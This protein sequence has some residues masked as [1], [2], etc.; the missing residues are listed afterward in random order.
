MS[1]IQLQ[2]PTTQNPGHSVFFSIAFRPFFAAGSLVG[3]TLMMVW[4]LIYRGQIQLPLAN[5]FSWH[6]HEMI[7]AYGMAIVAGFLLTAV[8][9]WT[10]QDTA[11]GPLLIA[12]LIVWLLPRP[13]ALI[14]PP[15]LYLSLLDLAFIPCLAICLAA[16]I[17]KS[18]NWRNLLFIPILIAF[19]L[20]NLFY[21][22]AIHQQIAINPSQPLLFA[23]ELLLMLI[24]IIGARVLPMFTRNGTQGAV[25]PKGFAQ[26]PLWLLA[27]GLSQLLFSAFFDALLPKA[28]LAL[29]FATLILYSWW[30]WQGKALWRNPMLWVLHIAYFGLAITY[31]LKAAS[32]F[33]LLPVSLWIH[34]A[35]VLCVGLMTVGFMGRV[36]LGHSGR[37]LHCSRLMLAS[38]IFML[39]AVV[40]RLA[41]GLYPTL[42]LWD[43]AALC[44]SLALLCFAIEFIPYLLSPRADGKSP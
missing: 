28:L 41:A 44:W 38:Y 43:S 39:L 40:L 7:Y 11:R 23:L 20:C 18:R 10:G 14:L 4:V 8:R 12:L 6:A 21:H 5:M 35:G 13:L 9:N 1:L 34:S 15:S 16:P 36:S 42:P 37:P 24:T 25:E 26:Q 22:L 33:S 2:E 17:I 32:Y 30:G 27:A 31:L 19:F 3:A 29:A